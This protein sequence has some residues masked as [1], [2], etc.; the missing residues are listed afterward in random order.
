VYIVC[1]TDQK[2]MNYKEDIGVHCRVTDQKNMN[3]K[4]DIGI[5]HVLLVS[6]SDNVHLCFPYNSC[7]SG[8]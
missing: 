2:N 3:Y 8:Q 5:I 6:D 4:E 1:V 7:S